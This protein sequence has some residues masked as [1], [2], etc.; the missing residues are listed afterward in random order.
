MRYLIVLG[1]IITAGCSDIMTKSDD[2]KAKERPKHVL[3]PKASQDIDEFKGDQEV[4]VPDVEVTNPYTA[5]LEAYEPVKQQLAQLNIQHSVRLFHALEG[6]YPKDHDEFMQRVIKENNVRLPQIG[7]GYE[8]QYD[9]AN[10]E[11]KIVKSAEP[12]EGG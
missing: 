4:V 10:H 1:L 5:G 11:L 9:V 3:M 7:R 6:R 2:A 8:Y 12:K